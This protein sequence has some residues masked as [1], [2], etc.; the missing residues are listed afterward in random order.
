MFQRRFRPAVAIVILGAA[1]AFASL[2]ALGPVFAQATPPDHINY[3]GVLRD[4]AGQPLTGTFGMIF[5][6]FDAESA[7]N[8]ILEEWH[9][10]YAGNLVLVSQG[11]FSVQLGSG[12]LWDGEG[13]GNYNSLGEVFRDFSS[14]W[15]E[16]QV[17]GETLAPRVEF[18]SAPYAINAAHINGR[19]ASD[20]L[21]TSA[22]PQTKAGTLAV[23]PVD[24][25]EYLGRYHAI[26][27]QAHWT[28]ES[29]TDAPGYLP[30]N[31]QFR[32]TSQLG[33][34]TNVELG[35]GYGF[36]C[37]EGESCIDMVALRAADSGSMVEL[38]GHHSNLL[39]SYGVYAT[40]EGHGVWAEGDSAGGRFE[41]RDQSAYAVIAT[42]DD[43][44]Q[45]YGN[46]VGGY[47]KDRDDTG[48]T[49]AGFG[50]HG[51]AA[52]GASSG[53][54]FSDSD[55][56]GYAHVG[57]GDRGIM[58][59]GSQAGG[60]FGDSDS[61]GYAWAGYGGYGI[62]AGGA[63]SGAYFGDTDQSGVARVGF[64]HLGIEAE[65][66]EAGGR[67]KDHE[68]SG[69]AYVGYGD[70]G[71]SAGGGYAG[72]Y[73]GS[74]DSSGY[75]RVGFGSVGIDAR[76]AFTPGYF[77]NSDYANWSTVGEH[78]SKVRGPGA[79][80]FVQN[81]PE[82]S[83]AVIVYFT[84]E[85][86]EVAV[87][88]RGTAR[89]QGGEVRVPLGETFKWVANPDL[90]LTVH[91]TPVGSWSDLY[92]ASKASDAI[93]VRSSGGD[94]NAVFDYIVYGLRIGFE[95]SSVLE[96]K[97]REAYIPS[98]KGQRELY[99]R[100]PEW[101]AGNAFERF[102]A[103]QDAASL[104]A[105]DLARAD[106]LRVAIHEYDPGSDPPAC[107]LRGMG[108]CRVEAEPP[109]EVARGAAPGIGAGGAVSVPAIPRPADPGAVGP[110][111]VVT[112]G[113]RQ[114]DKE[115]PPAPLFPVSESV[116]PGDLLV[117]DPL[118]PGQLKRCDAAGSTG[119]AGV[120]AAEAIT[121]NGQLQAPLASSLYALVKADAAFAVIRAGDLLTTSPTPG[122]AMLATEALPGTVIGK[123]LEPLEAGAGVIRV[124]LIAR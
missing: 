111:I 107:S 115:P 50:N 34:E 10:S 41:D 56:S 14:V 1:L 84:P 121:M 83:G 21:D 31:A 118:R 2:A 91:L 43:G 48:Y 85:G 39:P 116:E 100:R 23:G 24:F 108:P 18:V 92:V 27:S 95:E 30:I 82:D 17:N 81:H 65:G 79:N 7:G 19:T 47:F 86:D 63:D 73:F 97:S 74:T 5:R 80:S 113:D 75:A 8:E 49:L 124:L 110:A 62:I 78:V 103:M 59:Y 66:S 106:A 16:L 29:Y 72:G 98:M 93:V 69:Y 44:V 68:D 60:Y 26:L 89:L 35:T 3:Q 20:F 101:R 67:F 33:P 58:A 37:G 94:A 87:Y 64:G 38:A 123:A 76:A 104:P 53:G 45:G 90:G 15:L 42:A 54:W 114:D 105:A 119:V 102:R 117:L 120:V 46:Y 36:S 109:Q 122:H 28:W 77:A 55:N 57:T 12:P 99:E 61:S 112:R 13:P 9:D 52:G 96:E 40:S 4:A 25:G 88:T 6:Y 70:Y 51:I 22:I 11:I 71:V 32:T